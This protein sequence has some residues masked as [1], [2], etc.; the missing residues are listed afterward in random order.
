MALLILLNYVLQSS[1]LPALEIFGVA[2]DTALILI[3]GY[4]V[5]RGDVEG[6]VFGFFCGLTRDLFGAYYIGLFAMLGML[7]GFVCGKPFK[8]FFHDNALLPFIVVPLAAVAYQLA[9]YSAEFLFTGR[10]SLLQYFGGVIIPKTI[11]TTAFS[12]PV[13]S[14]LYLI[15][16]RLE[17]YEKN[18]RNLFKDV[19]P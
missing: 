11:Y 13:Y 15:N 2:P 1:V 3:V 8:D 16:G 9:V 6:A 18:R 17:R 5:L 14:L 4:G 7:T 19:E 12:M 10:S